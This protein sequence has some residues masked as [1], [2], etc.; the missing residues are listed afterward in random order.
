MQ[1]D[2]GKGTVRTDRLQSRLDELYLREHE[3]FPADEQLWEP[4]LES[5]VDCWIIGEGR[6]S[7]FSVRMEAESH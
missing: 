6:A 2:K 1:R 7:R 3:P 5:V 4:S